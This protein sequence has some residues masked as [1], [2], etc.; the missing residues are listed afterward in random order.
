MDTAK[1]LTRESDLTD[2]AVYIVLD[3]AEEPHGAVYRE[4][5]ESH[6]TKHVVLEN[7]IQGVYVRPVR[8][9][10]FDVTR[11]WARDVTVDMAS[12]VVQ[13]ARREHRVLSVSAQKFV[14]TV[15]GQNASMRALD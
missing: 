5:E 2:L 7:I 12:S 8:V 9:I 1:V 4:A 6:A 13:T 14:E 10:A 15:L 11:G 3:G